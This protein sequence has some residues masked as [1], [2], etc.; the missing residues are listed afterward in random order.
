MTA[1]ESASL[2]GY[3]D[4][5]FGGR[6]E[7]GGRLVFFYANTAALM[8]EEGGTQGGGEEEREGGRAVGKRTKK[9]VK[10]SRSRS[11]CFGEKDIKGEGRSCGGG[12]VDGGSGGRENR[13][14]G[15]MGRGDVR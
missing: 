5:Q 2:A 3:S 13:D 12:N 14:S 4:L 7:K 9:G 6:G 1:E 8:V 10:S 15:D 11:R